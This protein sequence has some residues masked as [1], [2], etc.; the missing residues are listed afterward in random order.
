M[1]RNR[2]SFLRLSALALPFSQANFLQIPKAV[3]K[4]V[5]ISTWDSGQI[6]NGAAWPIL[7]KGGRALD[8]VE[9]AAIAIENDINCCVGLGGNPDRDGHVTLD[10]SI[11]DEKSNCGSVAFMERIKHPISVARKLMETTPHV[12]LAGEGAQQFALANGFKLE[13]AA[14]SPSAKA[15]YDQWL[16]KAEYKPVINIELQQNKGNGPFAPARLDDGSFNHDTMGTLALDANGDVSGMCTTS[17]MGFKMRGRVGDSPI[18]G[19]GLFVDNEIGAATSSGQGEEVIRVCGTH[20][21]VEFMRSGLSPEQA[22][23]KAIERIVKPNPERAKTFQVG[24]IAINKKGEI[25]A[26]SI[27]KGFNYTVTEKGGKPKVIN[28]KSHFA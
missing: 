1:K 6:A 16:E 2:R 19:A 10:A 28:A 22:C 14:L 13:S 26:Y 8:A 25:G 18:I 17:G 15:T 20:L 11:M 3:N 27:L 21:V 24:F 23:K 9:Q 5:V 4:P 12:F 7:E